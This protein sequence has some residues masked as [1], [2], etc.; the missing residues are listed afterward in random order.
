MARKVKKESAEF[1]KYISVG[2]LIIGLL[3]LIVTALTWQP[4][5]PSQLAT[6]INFLTLSLGILYILFGFVLYKI[7]I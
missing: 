3:I 2:I 1:L 7:K 5:D 6:K 4:Y